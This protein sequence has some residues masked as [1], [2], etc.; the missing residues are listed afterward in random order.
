MISAAALK[1]KLKTNS[2]S[3]ARE[4]LKKE[5]ASCFKKEVS[6]KDLERDGARR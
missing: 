5:C 2:A 1:I 6:I 3:P 4:N